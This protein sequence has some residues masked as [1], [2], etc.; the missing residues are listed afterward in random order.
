MTKDAGPPIATPAGKDAAGQRLA[1]IDGWRAISVGLVIL[2]HASFSFSFPIGPSLEAGLRT[3]LSSL[4]ILGVHIFF[5]IS[6]Y[7]ITRG[8]TGEESETGRVSLIG[9]YV[10]RVFRILPPLLLYVLTILL[11]TS[12][13]AIPEY[14]FGAARALTFTCNFPDADC[15]HW[16]AAHTWSLSVEEQFYLVAP[17]F[18]VLTRR[19]RGIASV[20]AF[21]ALVLA[22]NWAPNFSYIAAGVMFASNEQV[23]VRVARKIP[24][25][26]VLAMI[27]AMLVCAR[28]L[29]SQYAWVSI[30]L[31]GSL[32]AAILMTTT[33]GDNLF[34]KMLSARWLVAVGQASY[35]IYLW[36]QLATAREFATTPLAMAI[37]LLAAIVSSLVSY[38]T[39]E[40]ALIRLSRR[41]S[42]NLRSSSRV[43][44]PGDVT[45][46]AN[47][48]L[49]D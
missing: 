22:S 19:W 38:N 45:E 9:F 47:K 7:V 46:K 31:Q 26:V 35:G 29:L 20:V 42:T 33:Y 32:I 8:M 39:W 30:A 14:G 28:A 37:L 2:F 16:T 5:V 10:R 43:V 44:R 40:R 11:L 15:G 49:A 36:Q 12:I 25:W 23:L 24:L 48:S 4:G 1:A 6:G 41:I 27:A 18:F 17:V 21:I 13:E 3:W 34:R